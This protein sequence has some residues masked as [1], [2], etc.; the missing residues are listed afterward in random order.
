MKRKVLILAETVMFVTLIG[1]LPV[2]G[3]AGEDEKL[4]R[5]YNDYILKC[6][7]KSQSKA[8]LQTS[9]YQNLKSCGTLSKQKFIFLTNNQDRLVDEMI[10]NKIGTK[11]YKIEYYLNQR[12]Y[13]TKR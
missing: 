7:S 6:I 12:F 3:Q 10:K 13:E 1:V 9:Q 11:S 5:Y 8:S 2:M 4:R